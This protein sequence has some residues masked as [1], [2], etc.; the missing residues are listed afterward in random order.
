MYAHNSHLCMKHK[1]PQYHPCRR[2][3]VCHWI[4]GPGQDTTAPTQLGQLS[5]STWRVMQAPSQYVQ[6]VVWVILCK[7]LCARNVLERMLLTLTHILCALSL[8]STTSQSCTTSPTATCVLW[9][10][11]YDASCYLTTFWTTACT[12]GV[13]SYVASCMLLMP[14]LTLEIPLKSHAAS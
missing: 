4:L 12:Y 1:M 5:K 7:T 13:L 2:C 9:T 11:R 3:R 8:T 14:Y 6:L 10:L